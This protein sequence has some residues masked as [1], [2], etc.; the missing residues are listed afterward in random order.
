[1]VL[2]RAQAGDIPAIVALLATRDGVGTAEDLAAYQ[3]AFEPSTP[4]AAVWA[5]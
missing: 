4:A 5:S 2:R 1:M 3:A